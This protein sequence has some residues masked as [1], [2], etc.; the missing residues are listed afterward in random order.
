MRRTAAVTVVW[1]LSVASAYGHP[2]PFSYLD[3]RL[4]DTGIEGSLVVHDLDVAH[5][6]GVDPPERF[7]DPQF[8]EQYRDQL[9]RLMESR[10]GLFADGRRVSITWTGFETLPERQSLREGRLSRPRS[11]G[12]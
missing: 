6:V 5:D 7:A 2:A 3:L 8:A 12:G 11:R 9:S 10:L 1:L 4:G